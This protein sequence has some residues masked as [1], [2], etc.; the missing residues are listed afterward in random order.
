MNG[1]LV[2]GMYACMGV[3][4]SVHVCV[5]ECARERTLKMCTRTHAHSPHR[6]AH[7]GGAHNFDYVSW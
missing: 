3:S 5:C 1:W 4:V 7:V 6:P 2:G